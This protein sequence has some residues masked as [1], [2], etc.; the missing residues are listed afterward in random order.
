MP[1][2]DARYGSPSSM[3]A[4]AAQNPDDRVD[5]VLAGLR[6][7]NDDFSNHQLP[8]GGEQLAGASVAVGTER[9]RTKA[10]RRQMNG[11]RVTVRIAGDLAEDPVAAASVGQG[12][13]RTQLRLRQIREWERNDNYPAG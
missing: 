8:A 2:L 10:G 6:A 11:S 12:D 3:D 1:S 9:A 7:E 5:Q 4:R 13:S